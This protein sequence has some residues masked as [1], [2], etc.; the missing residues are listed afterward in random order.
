LDWHPYICEP[1]DDWGQ[2]LDD[3]EKDR[4]PPPLGH[5]YYAPDGRPISMRE[6]AWW[7][8]NRTGDN[9]APGWKI[10]NFE[11]DTGEN[12][13]TV[14]LGLDHSWTTYG[15][16]PPVIFE[17]MIFGGPADQMMWRYSTIEEA[18]EGHLFAVHYAYEAR[19]LSSRF[20]RWA[21]HTHFRFEMWKLRIKK[22]F[23]R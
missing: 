12:V 19:K 11:L 13:S 17:T 8:E 2:S 3:F 5:G 20:W 7:M 4:T 9:P 18:R 15:E 14:W 23:S 22:R 10:G 6:W 21:R 1:P 16:G